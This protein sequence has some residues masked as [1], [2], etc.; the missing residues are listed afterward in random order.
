MILILHTQLADAIT[1]L[2]Y[3]KKM[4]EKCMHA[5]YIYIIFILFYH[6]LALYRV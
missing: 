2:K 1:S 4:N 3:Q 6:P 5:R